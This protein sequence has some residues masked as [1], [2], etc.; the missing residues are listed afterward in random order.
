MNMYFRSLRKRER[1]RTW[2]G[3][4][5]ERMS[6]QAGLA[7]PDPVW[8]SVRAIAKSYPEL[9]LLESRDLSFSTNISHSL[10]TPGGQG[11]PD[12]QG[13]FCGWSPS[14]S[15]SSWGDTVPAAKDLGWHQGQRSPRELCRKK[16][17]HT[18]WKAAMSWVCVESL[19]IHLFI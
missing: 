16:K 6:P 15:P 19:H 12:F 4:G 2:Q 3:K 1:S 5:P 13:Q 18:Y 8:G 11:G 9:S 14:F 17:A 7:W 10:N